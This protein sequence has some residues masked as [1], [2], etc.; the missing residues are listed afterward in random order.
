MGD[1]SQ[2]YDSVEHYGP[3]HEYPN[4][5]SGLNNTDSA[6]HHRLAAHLPNLGDVDHLTGVIRGSGHDLETQ[7]N[8]SLIHKKPSS[9]T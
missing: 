6:D 4:K 5:V 8:P 2:W 3:V 1:E 9:N 7:F